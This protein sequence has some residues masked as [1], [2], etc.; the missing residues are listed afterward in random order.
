MAIIELDQVG[1][2]YGGVHALTDVSF[3][4]EEGSITGLIGPNG[5][6]K[7]TLIDTL[8]GMTSYTG[9]IRYE[10]EAIDGWAAHKRSRHG[11]VRSFQSVELFHDLT[12]RENMQVYA[13]RH[14]IRNRLRNFRQSAGTDESILEALDLFGVGW[15]V[16]RFPGDL[17]HGIQRVVSI[18]RAL[19]SRPKVL[20]LDEPAAGL[21][22]GETR[23]LAAHLRAA[24]EK[25]G[26]TVFLIDHDM[27]LVL[28]HCETVHVINFGRWIASGTPQ[29]IREDPAVLQAYL[30]A[31]ETVPAG[32]EEGAR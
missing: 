17:P 4:V 24:V 16:D 31:P 28:G 10:G 18:A 27:D 15:T 13:D 12:V 2:R 21:E 5:A 8:T 30:G 26:V 7:T 29:M 9:S 14:G 20:L 6:G 19:V 11:L 22:A 23:E 1:V 3:T 25:L 32:S